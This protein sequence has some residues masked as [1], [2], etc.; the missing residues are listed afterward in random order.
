MKE[1]LVGLLV[2]GAVVA[3]LCFIIWIDDKFPKLKTYLHIGFW[4]VL[5][6]VFVG[7][8]IY[9]IGYTILHPEALFG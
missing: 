2:V 8:I 9:T 5:G 3:L 6:L 4:S 1:F 7:Y